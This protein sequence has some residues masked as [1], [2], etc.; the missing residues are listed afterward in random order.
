VFFGLRSWHGHVQAS[1][2]FLLLHFALFPSFFSAFSHFPLSA[3]L[4]IPSLSRFDVESAP[5][6]RDVDK[7]VRRCILFLCYGQTRTLPSLAVFCFCQLGQ[8]NDVSKRQSS[9][10]RGGCH[11]VVWV[12]PSFNKVHPFKY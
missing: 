2:S 9:F 3:C 10:L 6:A 7:M 12:S 5:C 4:D 1:L 11:P 8:T